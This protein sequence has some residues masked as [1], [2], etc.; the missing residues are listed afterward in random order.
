MR[1]ARWLQKVD[2]IG[3]YNCVESLPGAVLSFSQVLL[4]VDY[5]ASAEVPPK[6]ATP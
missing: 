2:C 6:Y 4:D 3:G 1:V 5:I